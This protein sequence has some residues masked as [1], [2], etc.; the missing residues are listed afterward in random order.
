MGECTED[1]I[2]EWLEGFGAVEEIFLMSSKSPGGKKELS[3]KGYVRF[4]THKDAADCAAAVPSVKE[5]AEGDVVGTWSESE[6]AMQR[7]TN[8]YKSNIAPLFLGGPG[9]KGAGG[10]LEQMKKLSGVTALFMY[11]NEESSKDE[12][13][14]KNPLAEKRFRFEAKC[15]DEQFSNLRAALGRA[16]MEIHERI[17]ERLKKVKRFLY[18]TGL[19]KSWGRE[20]LREEF[21]FYGDI[22]NVSVVTKKDAAHGSAFVK[23]K[24]EADALAACEAMHGREVAGAQGMRSSARCWK[25]PR[26]PPLQLR[27]ASSRPPRHPGSAQA[28]GGRQQH[29]GAPRR[30][31]GAPRRAPGAGHHRADPPPPGAA[32]S[33]HRLGVD[34]APPRRPPGVGRAR[35]SRPRISWGRPAS[36]AT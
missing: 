12:D 20:N 9:A 13:E 22:D 25:S 33:R 36:E 31:Q 26:C 21:S 5:E 11:A 14:T 23:F 1:Q 34:R 10:G 7:H 16:M 19:P 32:R 30:H 28:A 35:P 18:V 6:R 2:R 17:S 24:D 3:G 8:V 29:P 15:T 4:M 27:R